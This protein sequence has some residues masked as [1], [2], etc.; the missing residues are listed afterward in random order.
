SGPFTR[1]STLLTGT[2]YA[3]PVVSSNVYMVRAVKLEVMGSGSYFNP[4]QGII[5]SLDGSAGAPSIV[6]LQP[7]NNA[8]FIAPTTIQF[9]A[10]TFD[11]ANSIT[12]VAYYANG[13]KIGEAATLLPHSLIWS[14]VSPGS[15]SLT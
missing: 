13:E 12:N 14:N 11:P 7:T 6:L 1:L 3:D 5:Q 2:N 10:A 9:N 4:S 8:L 15:Y